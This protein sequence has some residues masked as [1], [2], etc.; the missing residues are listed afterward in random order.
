MSRQLQS[1]HSFI[2]SSLLSTF[3]IFNLLNTTESFHIRARNGKMIQIKNSEIKAAAR[4]TLAGEGPGPDQ[5]FFLKWVKD[6]Y[7]AIGMYSQQGL[8]WAVKNN[9]IKKG[10]GIHLEKYT[11]GINQQFKLQFLR[12]GCF[13]IVCAA[14]AGLVVAWNP[15]TYRFRL[16]PFLSGRKYRTQQYYLQA[17]KDLTELKKE[18]S[19]SELP[20]YVNPYNRIVNPDCAGAVTKRQ[21][22]KCVIKLSQ[23]WGHY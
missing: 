22:Y 10:K 15:K 4:L 12:R 16:W 3:L 19:D 5:D 21:F 6:D 11:G 20:T 9:E 1:S 18:D 17:Y 7:Y 8:V 23:G 13:K 2:L 14:N